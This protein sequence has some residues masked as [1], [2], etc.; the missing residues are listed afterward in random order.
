VDR[1]LVITG[2]FVRQYDLSVSFDSN[3]GTV[4]PGNGTYDAGT[5]VSLTAVPAFPYAFKTWTG[6]DS[7]TANPAKVTMNSDK[8]VS[9]SFV[10]LTKMTQLPT[11][12]RGNTYGTAVVSIDLSPGEWVEGTI[13][14]DSALPAQAVYIQGPDGQKLRD[15]GRPGHVTFQFQ[16]GADGKH[17]IVVKAN[18]ISTWGTNYTITYDVYG[19]Q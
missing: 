19:F 16:A 7:D 8:S 9:A 4:N 1:D 10:K 15:L 14:C 2:N 3:T 18:G 13:D 11:Q 5:Q 17:D 6:A 12:N